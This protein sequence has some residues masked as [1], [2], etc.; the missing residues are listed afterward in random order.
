MESFEILLCLELPDSFLKILLAMKW[1]SL[2]R[3]VL[4]GI[5]TRNTAFLLSK[6][7]IKVHNT[8]HTCVL[9]A[10]CSLYFVKCKCKF[11]VKHRECLRDHPSQRLMIKCLTIIQ[12]ELEFG[13]VSF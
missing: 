13:N 7:Q 9:V 1:L 6:D 4:V 8:R 12:I 3:N 10:K 2:N 11:N 5:V